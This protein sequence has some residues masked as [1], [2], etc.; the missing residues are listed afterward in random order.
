MRTSFRTLGGAFYLAACWGFSGTVCTRAE[1]IGGPLANPANGYV[2][3]LLS[4]SDWHAAETE[5]E[6]SADTLSP[7]TIKPSR[8]L[9]ARTLSECTA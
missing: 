3:Y 4:Q 9:S 7:S 6:N 8:I 1:I 5:A 2:Y